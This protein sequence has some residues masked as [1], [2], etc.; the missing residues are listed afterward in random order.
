MATPR[1][2]TLGVY[3]RKD[4]AVLGAGSTADTNVIVEFDQDI[5]SVDVVNALQRVIEKI[6]EDEY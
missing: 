4:L 1:T 3:E 2:V 6:L 5:P